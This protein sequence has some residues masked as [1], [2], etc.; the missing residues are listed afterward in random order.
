[1]PLATKLELAPDAMRATVQFMLRL[2][3]DGL[4]D[5]AP[6]EATPAADGGDY[7]LTRGS[8][9]GHEAFA[10]AS[11]A[12]ATLLTALLSLQGARLRLAAASNPM[13]VEMLPALVHVAAAD[14]MP[15]GFRFEGLCD[16]IL[17][18]TVNLSNAQFVAAVDSAPSATD[19]LHFLR[20]LCLLASRRVA[21]LSGPPKESL[22]FAC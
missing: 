1:M 18:F 20:G 13:A 21:S 16:G 2:H 14:D 8:N 10:L 17:S 4:R 22:S 9:A 12:A 5:T 19:R 11:N 6:P 7:R 3:A 15:G